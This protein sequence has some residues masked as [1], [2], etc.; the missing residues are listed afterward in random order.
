MGRLSALH[1]QLLKAY[2]AEEFRLISD[3]LD[4]P[5]DHLRGEDLPTRAMS[6]LKKLDQSNG[7]PKLI[8]HV[9]SERKDFVWRLPPPISQ[10]EKISYA[11]EEVWNKPAM[12]WALLAAAALI[13]AVVIGL[14]LRGQSQTQQVSNQLATVGAP[15]PT[16]TPG[17][18]KM[19]G[20]F[21]VAI[22]RFGVID[23]SGKLS[24][25]EDGYKLSKWI[26][27]GL[28]KELRQQDASV[29]IWHDS[30]DASQKGI[31]LETI[32]GVTEKERQ[33]N[34]ARLAQKIDADVLIFGNIEQKGFAPEY[35]INPR[36]KGFDELAGMER[37]GANV[38][39]PTPFDLND[40]GV[41]NFVKV[42]LEGRS[43]LLTQITLALLDDFIGNHA[44]ALN[45]L[46]T[47]VN[48]S[49]VT[50]S[51]K[52]IAWTLLGRQAR[53]LTIN[54]DRLRQAGFKS[55]DDALKVAEQ[56][57]D[58]SIRLQPNY[59]RAYY[60][61]GNLN[62]QRAQTLVVTTSVTL[63]ATREAAG[64][65]K[66]AV[67]DFNLALQKT[68]D[69]VLRSRIRATLGN[70]SRIVGHAFSQRGEYDQADAILGVA[71]SE[72]QKAVSLIDKDQTRILANT[73]LM[74]GLA[75]HEQAHT[76]F[77]QNKFAESKPLFEQAR[78]NYDAC[79]K[80]AQTQLL[81]KTLVEIGEK[82]CTVYAEQVRQ[83]LATLP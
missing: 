32:Y 49:S 80:L 54:D 5:F 33:D 50:V 69:D 31:A 23:A 39:V 12:R 76:K 51:G 17:K 28:D 71:I 72:L 56:A 70:T 6:L 59:A 1:E 45:K 74:L 82:Q 27:E 57:F 38:P 16:S 52:E 20:S 83:A 21:N 14:L 55:V 46:Q 43:K 81:D 22:A 53:L 2:N 3:S 77:L 58:E 42:E 64:M 63:T 8:E 75:Q 37:L 26:F 11:L 67:E 68:Q 18:Q 24:A 61:R 73:T 41:R 66:R 78:D 79:A 36:I 10:T 9:S 48:D 29:L 60:E 25:S 47:I 35:Y 44:A 19:D 13:A 15:G 62:A 4:I 7:L 34:A 30:M 40:P 65:L